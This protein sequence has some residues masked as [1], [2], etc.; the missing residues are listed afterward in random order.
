MTEPAAV[1]AVP[2]SEQPLADFFI[3]S[4]PTVQLA[5]DR[6][7]AQVVVEF[8]LNVAG[9]IAAQYEIDMNKLGS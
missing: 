5:I 9:M 7:G 6:Y 1:D 2:E 4:A 8:F 3:A